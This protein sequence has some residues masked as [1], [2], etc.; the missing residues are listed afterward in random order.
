MP[1]WLTLKLNNYVESLKIY[2]LQ[3]ASANILERWHVECGYCKVL[4]SAKPY[5]M[6]TVGESALR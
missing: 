3:L 1:P 2:T 5:H 6:Y 4:Q